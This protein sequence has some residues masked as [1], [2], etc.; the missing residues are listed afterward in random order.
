MVVGGGRSGR[1]IDDDGEVEVG[2][3]LGCL[4]L[5]WVK[6]RSLASRSWR[7]EEV[8]DGREG[9][10]GLVVMVVVGPLIGGACRATAAAAFRF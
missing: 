2:S 1:D 7:V 8:V 4:R 5:F 10:D 9:A 3:V 6:A